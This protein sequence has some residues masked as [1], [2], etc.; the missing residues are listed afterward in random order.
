V[1]PDVTPVNDHE[2]VMVLLLRV[3]VMVSTLPL[4]VA[5][6]TVNSKFPVVTP[7]VLPVSVN[8]PVSDEIALKQGVAVLKVRLLP[9]RVVL[10]LW[11]SDV[12]NEKT[13]VPSGFVSVALQFP[14]MLFELPLPHA[15]NISTSEE[16][17]TIAN[18]LITTPSWAWEPV[19]R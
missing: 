4:G 18:C 10:L 13:V 9:L 1:H 12:V 7:L 16:I 19:P 8:P 11:L 6:C 3:P 14:L 2:P 15:P 5:D 17:K